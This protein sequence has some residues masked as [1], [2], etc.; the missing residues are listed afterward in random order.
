MQV[1]VSVQKLPGGLNGDDGGGKSV[2]FR[3]FPEERGKSLP[4]AQGEFGEK[5]SPMSECRPQDLGEREDEMPV[6]DGAEHLLPDEFHP[7]GGAFGAAGGA[8]S[9]LFAG[10]GDEIFVSANIASDAREAALGKA[11]PEKALDGFRDDPPSSS[12]RRSRS[13][14]PTCSF[15]SAGRRPCAT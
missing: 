3:V 10:E 8:E 7:Q 14:W 5:P 12:P 11:A 15:R 13:C 4:G 6:G 1:G 2:P 9:S